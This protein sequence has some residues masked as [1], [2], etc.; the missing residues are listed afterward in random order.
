MQSP[1]P[2]PLTHCGGLSWERGKVFKWI[3]GEKN[4]E[5]DLVKGSHRGL[6]MPS[7]H[8]SK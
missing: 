3:P 5:G 6:E 8:V 1:G 2:E 7:Q 4:E